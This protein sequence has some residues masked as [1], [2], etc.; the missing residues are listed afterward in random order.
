MLTV[1]VDRIP[2]ASFLIMENM[3][4][5]IRLFILISLALFIILCLASCFNETADDATE[6]QTTA[7]TASESTEETSASESASTTDVTEE[8]AE[9]TGETADVITE[10][11]ITTATE[12][13]T[14]ATTEAQTEQEYVTYSFFGAVGDG[15]KDDFNAIYAAHA[16]ANR[17]GLPVKATDGAVYYIGQKSVGKQVEIKTDTDWTGA[18]FIIDDRCVEVNG[19]KDYQ[20]PLFRIAPSVEGTNK[21]TKVKYLNSGAENI[22]Y[23]PG[24]KCLG[25][26]ERDYPYVFIRT[27]IHAGDGETCKEIL[28]I[29]ENGNIDESTP[30]TWEY[31]KTSN[32]TIYHI[33][34]T[35]LTVRGGEF[36][37]LTNTQPRKFTYFYRNI[38]VERS[39]VTLEGIT[40]LTEGENDDGGAPYTGFIYVHNC[41]NVTVKDC[42]F[43]PHYIFADHTQYES[44][45]YG[46]D[47]HVNTATDVKFI[48]C[49]QTISIDD[50]KYWGV[51]T[52][53]FARNL[54]L[55][56]CVLSRFDAHRGVYNVDIR[57][58]TFGHQGI[59]FVGFGLFTVE[60]TTVRS[61]NLILLRGDYGATF[62]GKIVIRNCIFDPQSQLWSKSEL[63]NARNECDHYYGYKCFF[64]E[65]EIDGLII[66]DD[67]V[68]T[69]YNGIYILP[70]YTETDA[71]K[72]ADEKCKY[73]TPGRISLSGIVT[74]SGTPYKICR[75]PELYPGLKVE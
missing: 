36:L 25:V 7:M 33:D 39:N 18:K 3:K 61:S 6:A 34:Q 43:T 72:T 54:T 45:A 15:V 52:S 23:V 14:E 41:A 55:E 21:W 51:F 4:R 16:Y 58:C 66:K 35:E 29:D 1:A 53:N 68:T 49:T 65:I 64:P 56:D 59:R 31:K 74:S 70:V 2:S 8:S 17:V 38:T 28:L 73:Y 62:D 22:G 26:I 75:L 47:V 37:T 10:E 27:G 71:W 42:V 63:I 48:G 67:N 60:D 46:Y 11:S 50:T 57:R 13:T 20:K 5:T 32:F 44:A 30:L 9:S 69:G 40:H 12:E 19:K 24:E